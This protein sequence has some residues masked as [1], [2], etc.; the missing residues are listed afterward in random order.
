MQKPSGHLHKTAIRVDPP[1]LEEGKKSIKEAEK[2]LDEA[3]G[4]YDKL[5]DK[6]Q[7]LE[8]KFKAAARRSRHAREQRGEAE[9]SYYI[10][11]K[12]ARKAMRHA[13]NIQR[14]AS[15]AAA[16]QAAMDRYNE[17]VSAANKAASEGKKDTGDKKVEHTTKTA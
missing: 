10:A 2:V 8:F 7:D 16:K 6:A 15:Q 5:K 9:D 14:E 3:K 12:N 13:E 17:V 11:A 4:E 1:L